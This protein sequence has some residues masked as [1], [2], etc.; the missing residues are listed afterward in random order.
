MAAPFLAWIKRAAVPA[1]HAR[2]SLADDVTFP[3]WNETLK[4]FHTVSIGYC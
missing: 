1:K 4:K 3:F 2:S